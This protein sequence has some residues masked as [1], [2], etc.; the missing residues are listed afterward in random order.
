MFYYVSLITICKSGDLLVHN[1]N[2][3]TMGHVE[4]PILQPTE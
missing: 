2:A 3:E 4:K 1:A